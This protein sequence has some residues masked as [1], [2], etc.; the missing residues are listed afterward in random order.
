MLSKGI[1]TGMGVLS[2]W[3]C[4]VDRVLL[5]GICTRVGVLSKVSCTMGRG[6]TQ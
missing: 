4:T 2:K 3:I 1:C 6:A 5:K